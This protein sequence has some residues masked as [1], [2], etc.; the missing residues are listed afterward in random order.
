MSRFEKG[1]LK[2]KVDQVHTLIDPMHP[3]NT[4]IL[5]GVLWLS[6]TYQKILM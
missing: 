3:V 1:D 2:R 5:K 6:L 4:V